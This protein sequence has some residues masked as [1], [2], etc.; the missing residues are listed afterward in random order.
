MIFAPVGMLQ[1]IPQPGFLQRMSALNNSDAVAATTNLIMLKL[2][3]FRRDK[4][5][6][7]PLLETVT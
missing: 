7:I 6:L 1:W 4:C 5:G 2:A 3:L